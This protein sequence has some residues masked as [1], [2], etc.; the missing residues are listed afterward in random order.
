VSFK[1]LEVAAEVRIGTDGDS[2]PLTLHFMRTRKRTMPILKDVNDIIK[3]CQYG[4]NYFL[5]LVINPLSSSFYYWIIK[6]YKLGECP[7]VVADIQY[8]NH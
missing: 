1:H 4:T 8:N 5:S 6:L 3:P 7:R 2:L